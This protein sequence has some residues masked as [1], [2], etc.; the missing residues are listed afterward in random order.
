MGK[1]IV[2]YIPLYPDIC[3]VPPTLLIHKIVGN[4]ELHKLKSLGWKPILRIREKTHPER[5]C[6]LF[7]TLW[8]LTLVNIF[9]VLDKS[10][11]NRILNSNVTKIEAKT[12]PHSG[13]LITPHRLGYIMMCKLIWIHN[14]LVF[15]VHSSW[16]T[17]KSAFLFSSHTLWSTFARQRVDIKGRNPH[18]PSCATDLNTHL[19]PSFAGHYYS[20]MN[21]SATEVKKKSESTRRK[22][23]MLI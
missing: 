8:K 17:L 11:F 3:A 9:T 7:H 6:S 14:K 4:L 10:Y 23:I 13:S 22:I 16:A 19:K 20:D 5:H 21:N 12:F 15:I 1:R 2:A 18:F